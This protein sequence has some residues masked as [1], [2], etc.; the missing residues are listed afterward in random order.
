MGWGNCGTDSMGRPIGYIF[1]ATCDHSGCKEKINRGLG[2][3]CGGMHSEDEYSCEGYFCEKH[4]VVVELPNG[5]CQALCFKCY[6]KLPE[7]YK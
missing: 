1:E 3:A 4:K 2:Y 7:E 6:E 5:E